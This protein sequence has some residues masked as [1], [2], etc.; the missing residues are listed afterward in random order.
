MKNFVKPSV[1]NYTNF[2][3]RIYSSKK[4][5]FDGCVELVVKDVDNEEMICGWSD[6]LLKHPLKNTVREMIENRDKKVARELCQH[7]KLSIRFI[8]SIILNNID[9][10]IQR[11]KW[12]G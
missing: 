5:E 4:P 8:S 11:R 10:E 3:V 12:N 6:L 9:Y 1:P 7:E 2:H